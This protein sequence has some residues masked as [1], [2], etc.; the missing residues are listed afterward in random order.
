M[1]IEIIGYIAAFCTTVAFV[2]QVIKVYK[3]RKT[4]DISF[5]M[6]LLLTTGMF[7]WAVYGFIL[8]SLPIIIANVVTFSLAAYIFIMKIKLD[9]RKSS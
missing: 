7:C 8:N 4:S 2:P 5:G 9:L 6:F 3:S 1:N